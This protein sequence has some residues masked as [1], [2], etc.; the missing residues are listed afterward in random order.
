[1]KKRTQRLPAYKQIKEDLAREIEQLNLAPNSLFLS[2]KE[3]IARFSVSRVTI[4]QAFDLLEQDG[5]IYRVQGKGSFIGPHDAKPTKTVAFVATCILSNGVESVLLRSI[6]DHLD[7]YNYNLIICNNNNQFDKT[8]NYIKRLIRSKVDAIIYVCVISETEYERNA[9]L[10][11]YVLN[12]NTPIVLVDRYVESMKGRVFIITPDNYK[13]AYMMAEHL[14]SLGHTRIGYFSGTHSSSSLDR[15]S[16]LKAC[17]A[18]NGIAFRPE[19]AKHVY[20]AED[21]RIVAMQYS[22][23]REKPTAIMA[24]CDDYAYQ[25]IEALG[26]FNIAAPEDIAVTGFDDYSTVKSTAPIQLTTIRVPL[27][28]EGTLTASL[29]VDLL[30]GHDISPAHVKVPCE[31]VI[32]ETCGVKQVG[33]RL[34][35]AGK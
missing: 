23:M 13:G 14:I 33:R 18:D 20:T 24:E 27:W 4:R 25:L 32:R 30:K 11:K 9:E 19:L 7:K 17:L 12:N 26:A 8:E 31:L 1:M 22:M 28:E 3:A 16:G 15:L 2:E 21:Y 10:I 6:E 5:Y 34:A 35:M 29:V